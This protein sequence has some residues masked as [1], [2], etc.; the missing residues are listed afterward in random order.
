MAR[1]TAADVLVDTL[2]DWGVDTIFGVPADGINGI[3]EALRT[4]QRTV[5]VCPDTPNDRD[6]RNRYAR[7]Y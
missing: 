5:E 3:I 7:C 6:N 4:Q 1:P 2:I